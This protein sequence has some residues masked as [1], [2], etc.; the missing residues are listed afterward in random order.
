MELEAEKAGF[1][2]STW[3]RV[4][5]VPRGWLF[6]LEVT[7]LVFSSEL[8]YVLYFTLFRMSLWS[9]C[10]KYG[11]SFSFWPHEARGIPED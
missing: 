9:S 2:K 10:V 3:P 7:D 5:G 6:L 8:K 11:C 4:A 1:G